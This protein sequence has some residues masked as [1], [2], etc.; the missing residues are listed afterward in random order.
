MFNYIH[1]LLDKGERLLNRLGFVGFFHNKIII[2]YRGISCQVLGK[3]LYGR[4]GQGINNPNKKNAPPLP[5][6]CETV[7]YTRVAEGALS[8]A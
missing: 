3:K 7:S 2:Y 8:D 5:L 1:A 6:V 4:S